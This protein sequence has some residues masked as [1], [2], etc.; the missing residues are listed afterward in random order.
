MDHL[1]GLVGGHSVLR[2]APSNQ[3]TGAGTIAGAKSGRPE[4]YWGAPGQAAGHLAF[5]LARGLGPDIGTYRL[6]LGPQEV[7]VPVKGLASIQ[8]TA[9]AGG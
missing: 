7:H 3:V 9:Q 5:R 8:V 4:G 6:G 1:G 2:A